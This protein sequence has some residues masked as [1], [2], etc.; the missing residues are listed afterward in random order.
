MICYS[1][2]KLPCRFLFLALL[3]FP[4]AVTTSH[5]QV[6]APVTYDNAVISSADGYATQAG[7]ETLKKG[8]IRP[9][10]RLHKGN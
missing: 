4:T 9:D 3:L 2:F 8:G 10:A 7:I 1:I 6:A 5:A